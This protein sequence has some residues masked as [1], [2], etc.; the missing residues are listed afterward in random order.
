M[1]VAYPIH[2]E[3]FERL[4]QDWSTLER[5]QRT[6]GVLRL[7]AT[8]VHALWTSGDRSPMILPASIPLDNQKVFE[9]IT[10]HLDDTW[11]PIVDAD[12]AGA[13]SVANMIDS[14]IKILGRSMATKRA[15]RCVFLGYRAH[16]QPTRAGRL[17][18]DHS[19]HAAE[20]RRARVDLP[21]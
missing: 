1:K 21:G 6:R 15:A 16:G 3:L 19:R 9:E 14:E 4:Y 7:M 8:V 18:G 13:N 10:N 17:G 5:F 12:I 2:P 20:T 11:K